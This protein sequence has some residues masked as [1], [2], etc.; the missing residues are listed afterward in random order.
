[1]VLAVG[2]GASPF[3][4]LD[5]LTSGYERAGGSYVGAL[6]DGPMSEER[7][8]LLYWLNGALPGLIQTL[9]GA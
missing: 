9:R 3:E 6:R 4:A 2:T 5:R 7:A 1:M 8:R